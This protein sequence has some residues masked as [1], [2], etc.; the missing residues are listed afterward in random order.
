MTFKTLLAS[1]A[2]LMISVSAAGATEQTTVSHNADGST[3]TTTKTF[4]YYS[5][6]DAN[7]NGILDAQEFPKY[8]YTRWDRNNDGFVTDDEWQSN[9]VRWY[10]PQKTQYYKVEKA[11][12]VDGNGRLDA[13]EFDNV[14]TT[15]KLY[16][17]WDKNA[18]KTLTSEEYYEATF[19]VYDTNSDGNINY[20]EWIKAQ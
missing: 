3:T 15:T 4:Y 20:E 13:S 11:W 18:D 9:A 1:A 10:G 16:D 2:A 12:D 17:T 14:I 6:K 7:N 5:D 8:V 19:R